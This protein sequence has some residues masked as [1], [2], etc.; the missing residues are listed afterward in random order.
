[1]RRPLYTL[2]KLFET[3]LGWQ[4]YAQEGIHINPH[5]NVFRLSI[6]IKSGFERVSVLDDCLRAA[7]V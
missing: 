7:L 4:F 5:I 6:G 3:F 1:M 2:S